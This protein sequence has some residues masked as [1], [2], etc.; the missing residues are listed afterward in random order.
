LGANGANIARHLRVPRSGHMRA[1]DKVNTGKG[2]RKTRTGRGGQ[3]T[4]RGPWHVCA[5]EGARPLVEQVRPQVAVD[6][7][8]LTP[9]PVQP[10]VAVAWCMQ[11]P[12]WLLWGAVQLGVDKGGMHAC[13]DGH[14]LASW[15]RG[16][17]AREHGSSSSRGRGRG[18]T[19]VGRAVAVVRSGRA[20]RP[21]AL[22]GA[23]LGALLVVLVRVRRRVEAVTKL[24]RGAIVS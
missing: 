24:V 22:L 6:V 4:H 21:R 1:C 13:A 12:T 18:A 10:R 20:V 15:A 3:G 7:R 11:P 5:S 23:L 17:C 16:S 9:K 19:V 2:D 14:A 8:A